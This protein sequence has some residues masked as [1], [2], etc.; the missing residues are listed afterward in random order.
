M[1]KKIR[2]KILSIKRPYR[3]LNS[4][5][6]SKEAILNNLKLYRDLRPDLSICPVL[7]GNAYGHGLKQVG[8]IISTMEEPP[9]FI[10]VDS[11]YEAYELK[12]AKVKTPVLILG[13]N[14]ESNLKGRKLPYHFVLSNMELAEFFSKE[15]TPVHLE[16]DTGM[17]RMGFNLEELEIELPKLKEMNLNIV[18]VFTHFADADN[19][20]TSTNSKLKTDKLNNNFTQLQEENFKKAL[21]MIQEAGFSPKWIHAGNSA[22]SLKSKIPELNMARL[23]LGLYGIPPLK[24]EDSHAKKLLPLSPALELKS[25]LIQI[26]KLKKGDKVGYGCSFEASKNMTIGVIPLGY[27][28]GLPRNLSNK[29]HVE[30]QG[31]LCPIIGRICMNHTLFDLKDLS[32]INIG[33]SVIIYSRNQDQANSLTQAAQKA[34]TIPYELM[35]SLAESV[36]RKLC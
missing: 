21:Q 18:G 3:S 19:P 4:I 13:Y 31:T 2:N 25:T 24:K 29:G 26:R 32:E 8:Q 16:I 33:E 20:E 35:T 22:G 27:Y 9:P 12:K 30:I 11:L 10:I 14:H 28:E 23:G 6:I 7:K 36:R 34:N 5:F 15:Q 17:N 1:F